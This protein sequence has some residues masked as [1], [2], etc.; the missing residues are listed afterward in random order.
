MELLKKLKEKNSMP[1]GMF[2]CGECGSIVKRQYYA[3]IN[4]RSCGCIP[5]NY[6]HGSEG[7]RLYHIWSSM[8]GRCNRVKSYYYH[9]YGGRGIKVHHQWKESFATFQDWALKNGY[10]DELQ[11]DRK[12]NDG[13]YCPEN[14]RFLTAAKNIRN[15][16]ITRLKWVHVDAIRD[17]YKSNNNL[18]QKEIGLLFGISQVCVSDII[19]FKTWCAV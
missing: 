5:S 7:T 10:S 11:L 6:K 3:G 9:R 15:S 4:Q 2:K 17:I 18:S 8:I 14:C 1:F 19:T 13:N 12:N 16:T